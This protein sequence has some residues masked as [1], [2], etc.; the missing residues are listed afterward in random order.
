MNNGR[1]RSE[2]DHVLVGTRWRL[3]KSYRVYRSAQF[4]TDHSLLAAELQISIKSKEVEVLPTHPG[5]GYTGGLWRLGVCGDWGSFRD[6]ITTAAHDTIGV[7]ASG[8]VE[9]D[10][11][12]ML[13]TSSVDV[14]R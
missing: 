7:D 10:F 13:L 12:P 2:I 4:D 14:A 6:R 5:V 8:N 3:L 1:D 11:L 9:R